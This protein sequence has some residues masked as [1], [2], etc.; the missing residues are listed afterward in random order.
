[1]KR[2]RNLQASGRLAAQGDGGTRKKI[3]NEP[4]ATETLSRTNEELETAKAELEK[5]NEILTAL[6]QSAP[7]AIVAVDAA[8]HIL[9]ANAQAE[10]IFGYTRQEMIG[11]TIEMLMPA[12]F[13]KD[14][15]QDR[16]N[17]M[18][19]QRL[20][21]MGAGLELYGRRKDGAEFPVDIMLSPIATQEGR[22]V[23][24]IVRD[25]T[26][27]KRLDTELR[28]S[29]E[30][31]RLMVERVADYAI[32][33]L[34]MEGRVASWNAGA[35]RI[36][37]YR[38]EEILGQHF[39]RFYAS[40]DIDKPNREL[41]IA[42]ATG[43]FEEE[44]LRVRKDG[45][46]FYA[47]VLITAT[48]DEKGNLCGFTKVVRD[49]TER[50]QAEEALRKSQEQLEMRVQ[51]RTAELTRIN[52]QLEAEIADRK[53]AEQA[54]FQTQ[55]ELARAVR[56]IT[57][58]ELAASIAHELNQPL[59]GVVTNG[60]ACLRWLAA[61]PPN[62]DEA[63]EAVGRIIRDG[64]RASSVLA[65][66][67]ALMKKGEPVKESLDMNSLIE[68][69]LALTEGEVRRNEVSLQTELAADL[70]PVAGDR[71]QL[72]QVLLNLIMNAIE[73]MNAVKD[74]TRDLCI[75]TDRQDPDA[76]LIAV[77]DSGIGLDPAQLERIFD[78]FNT[79][80]QEGIGMGLSI[81]RSIIEAH[82]GRLWAV[83]NE[84]PGVTL[85]FSLPIWGGE[86]L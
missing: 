12:R 71:V 66:V 25:I 10:S 56:V 42:A 57:T 17:Y 48:R 29:E 49:I 84:G 21:A 59:T 16:A 50:K 61:Q 69:I 3:A 86:T 33:M 18:S 5:L 74:R 81:S 52:K 58:G 28:R 44:G 75:R 34:D 54:L 63:R 4:L 27:R 67:R 19:E 79:T 77:Q 26:E 82:G 1:V 38:A 78:A 53:A 72:Q 2:R 23:I 39:S 8:G 32:F 9:R 45:S 31:F 70:L 51:E 35:E 85:R 37:G 41:E 47:S 43:H 68:E 40:E 30:R 83:L 6:F 64:N 14:H 80:K 65:R 7:D 46:R 15:V 62:L 20:R 24:A 76:V 11:Q 60:N 22:G 55:L 36:N 73:A 13:Q